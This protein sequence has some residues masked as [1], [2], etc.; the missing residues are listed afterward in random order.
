MN[1]M[2]NY[3][4][5]ILYR[6]DGV[7]TARCCVVDQWYAKFDLSVD[8]SEKLAVDYIARTFAASSD[9]GSYTAHLIG[10]VEEKLDPYDKGLIAPTEQVV[11][12]FEQFT[13]DW[14]KDVGGFTVRSNNHEAHVDEVEAKAKELNTR[15]RERVAAIL[16]GNNTK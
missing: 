12:E 4:T 8:V 7:M 10:I 15:I 16:T 1:T 3:Y 14:K 13:N 5:L 11:Y 9:G 6:P 2:N